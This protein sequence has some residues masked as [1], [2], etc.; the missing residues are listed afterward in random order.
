MPC[1][2]GLFRKTQWV[3]KT[4]GAGLSIS[5]KTLKLSIGHLRMI[6]SIK[7]WYSKQNISDSNS[8][9][10]VYFYLNSVLIGHH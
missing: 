1:S 8:R 2:V 5:K 7:I 3:A 9:G 6:C 4:L 10:V